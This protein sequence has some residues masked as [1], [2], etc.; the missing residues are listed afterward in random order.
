MV[1]SL[2]T[3]SHRDIIDWDLL[4]AIDSSQRFQA[5]PLVL[6]DKFRFLYAHQSL[7]A[8]LRT[9]YADVKVICLSLHEHHDTHDLYRLVDIFANHYWQWHA[10]TKIPN[11][12]RLYLAQFF[13]LD[14]HFSIGDFLFFSKN[15]ARKSLKLSIRLTNDFELTQQRKIYW[16]RESIWSLNRIHDILVTEIF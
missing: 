9:K 6:R 12:S 3:Y 13:K 11:P 1:K 8:L 10:F 15:V 5:F 7:T 16:V 14:Q 2:R 4:N